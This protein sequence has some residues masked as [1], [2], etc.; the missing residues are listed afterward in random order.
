MSTLIVYSDISDSEVDCGPGNW[1]DVRVGSDSKSVGTATDTYVFA[2]ALGFGVGNCYVRQ[3]FHEFDTSSL[4]GVTIAGVEFSIYY[5]GIGTSETYEVFA[6]DFGGTVDA[7]DFVSGD[8]LGT[9]LASAT[10]GPGAPNPIV[11]TENGSNFSSAIVQGGTTSILVAGQRQRI[12]SD[13]SGSYSITYNSSDQTGTT[14][15]PKLTITYTTGSAALTGTATASISEADIVAGGKTVILTL[16]GDTFVPN[17]T[18]P[19]DTGDVIAG[20]GATVDRAGATAWTSP[21]NITADD[22]SYAT[23]VVPTDYLLASNFG[24][25]IP[26][27]ATILGVTVKVNA[28]ESGTGSSNY[29][30]QLMSNTTPTLIGLA[31]SAVS[32]NGTTKVTSTNGGTGDLWSATLTPAIVNNSGFGVA[33]WSTDTV[34]TLSIDWV[35]I[36]IR[37]SLPQEF[38]AARQDLI[39]GGDSAQAEG[40]GWDSEVKANQGVSGVVR[41]SNTVAT[42]TLDAQAGYDI[43]AQEEITWTIP[44]SIL[45]GGIPLVATPTFTI[46]PTGSPV[47]AGVGSPLIESP[48]V[49]GRLVL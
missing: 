37:Y 25:A 9:V 21:G 16:T 36:S 6:K 41:T 34:N 49:G 23:A 42:I 15:D 24:F 39:D 28:S 1:A 26:S 10:K 35:S 30:P 19:V 47:P 2:G 8:S 32:V 7:G 20:T 18:S 33:I 12:D 29:V 44:G 27:N 4:V 40:T 45:T 14:N 46:D 3:S 5:T 48:L 31:K 43:T 38:D 17:P 13:P 11:F 22:T